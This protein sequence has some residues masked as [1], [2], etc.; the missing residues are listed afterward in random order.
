MMSLSFAVS[1]VGAL[2]DEVLLT[3][4]TMA[5][6]CLSVAIFRILTASKAFTTR[7]GALA[8]S[9]PLEEHGNVF[10][11]EHERLASFAVP[12][13]LAFAAPFPP[14]AEVSLDYPAEPAYGASGKASPGTPRFSKLGVNVLCGFIL[15]HVG[16][17]RSVH[18]FVPA[19]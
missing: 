12:S 6:H 16:E 19:I 14:L 4:A 15:G 13:S 7:V 17:I 2:V 1:L 10:L 9:F 8:F 3:A 18:C 5:L 11:C